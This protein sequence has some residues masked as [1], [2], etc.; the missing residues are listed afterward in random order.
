MCD[1][2][3]EWK[4]AG[5]YEQA[6]KFFVGSLHVWIPVSMHAMSP[7]IVGSARP[8]P[9][10]RN[11]GKYVITTRSVIRTSNPEPKV[12]LG[13]RGIVSSTRSLPQRLRISATVG[14]APYVT[15]KSKRGLE[16]WV[17]P[18]G[19]SCPV[20]LRHQRKVS[21]ITHHEDGSSVSPPL[22]GPILPAML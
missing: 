15:S 17:P 5:V 6:G 8:P 9:Q 1:G 7:D 14:E 10:P 20:R 16:D 19:S 18:R 4:R 3:S 11:A 13:V 21:R 2:G 22:P 12:D